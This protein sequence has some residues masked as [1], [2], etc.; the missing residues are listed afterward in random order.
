MDENG[1]S[2]I[3]GIAGYLRSLIDFPIDNTLIAAQELVNHLEH[4]GYRIVAIESKEK[5][6]N[7]RA[8][9]I[10]VKALVTIDSEGKWHVSG[11]SSLSDEEMREGAW[12]EDFGYHLHYHWLTATIPIPVEKVIECNVEDAG[13]E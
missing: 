1:P 7:S 9:T 11:D 4:L 2:V 10:E 6:I 12:I 5:A 8:K 13:H 3:D